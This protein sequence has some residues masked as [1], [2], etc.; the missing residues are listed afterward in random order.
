M[1]YWT[2][3]FLFDFLAYT[4]TSAL[5][6]IF[7]YCWELVFLLNYI[8]DLILVL[9]TFGISLI[10]YS[11]VSGFLFKKVNQADLYF[12]LINYFI[13]WIIPS[14]IIIFVRD[15]E[16]LSEGIYILFYIISPFYTLDRAFVNISPNPGMDTGPITNPHIFCLIFLL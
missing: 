8:G 11:F 15:I 5:F 6:I 9:F 2:G 7:I 13:L 3:T 10:S 4:L 16:I 1:P 12:P 14:G